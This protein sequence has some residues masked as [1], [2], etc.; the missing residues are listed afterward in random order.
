MIPELPHYLL[1]TT[2]AQPELEL[3]A[4]EL[5][6]ARTLLPK[7]RQDF[8]LGRLAARRAFAALAV[9]PHEFSV[10]AADDGAPEPYLLEAPVPATLS[11]SHST[12]RALAVVRGWPAGSNDAPACWLGADCEQMTMLT[13]ALQED[14]F[15]PKERA[16]IAGTA[17]AL[18]PAATTLL[19]SA[20]ESAL[21]ASRQG[22]REAMSR[23]EVHLPPGDL[24]QASQWRP[25][26]VTLPAAPE[27]LFGYWC[28]RA[29]LVLTVVGAALWSC[30]V[31]LDEA[32]TPYD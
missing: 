27:G 4:A 19:W 15:T 25:F 26:F 8:T 1:V 20:K 6:H 23:V 17:L 30:P 21:K 9:P 31:A 16:L 2:P 22:L 11:L 10:R 28:Q 7:R 29:D 18:Q 14:H 3:S 12:G 24:A 5:E 13:A 32:G